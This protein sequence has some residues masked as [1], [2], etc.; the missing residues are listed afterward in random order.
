MQVPYRIL[1]LAFT[2]K[3]F[4]HGRLKAI[5]ISD[6]KRPSKSSAI[7]WTNQFLQ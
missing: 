3:T 1:I 5:T 7:K 6:F 2:S 4:G